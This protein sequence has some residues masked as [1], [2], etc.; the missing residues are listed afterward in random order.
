MAEAGFGRWE[1]GIHLLWSVMGLT[2]GTGGDRF[3]LRLDW[4]VM[5]EGNSS[6]N[7]HNPG[8]LLISFPL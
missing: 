1:L 4:E 3:V 7:P 6:G 8:V 5:G 2:W